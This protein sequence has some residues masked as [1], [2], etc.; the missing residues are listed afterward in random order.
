MDMKSDYVYKQSNNVFYLEKILFSPV[1]V[2]VNLG[3]AIA[4]LT[5]DIY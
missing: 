1:K 2:R 4:H 3:N 5:V